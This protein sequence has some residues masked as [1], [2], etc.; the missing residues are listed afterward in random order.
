MS[1]DELA[2]AY[3]VNHRAFASE[4]AGLDDGSTWDI[5]LDE[6][7]VEEM[8]SGD[9]PLPLIDAMLALA[10]EENDLGFLHYVAAGPIEDLITERRD[11]W[12][13]LAARCRRNST[14]AYAVE[15]GVRVDGDLVRTLPEPLDTLLWRNTVKP[16]D[17]SGRKP[18][19]AARDR[20]D[21]RRSRHR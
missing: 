20:T 14:W 2:H 3:L 13:D 8:R 21:P 17:G 15:H 12:R 9:D 7:V 11:L 16:A 4:P 10:A 5:D 6:H 18:R 19:K 1:P